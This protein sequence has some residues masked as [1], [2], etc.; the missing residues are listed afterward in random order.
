MH[1]VWLENGY[2][3]PLD[4]HFNNISLLRNALTHP[5]MEKKESLHHYERLEFL[6]N[7]IVNMIIGHLLYQKY[8]NA[9]EGKL[10]MM[11]SH[12]VD[13]N[14]LSTVA[15]EIN[16]AN[17]LIA[18]ASAHVTGEYSKST[19][20]DSMESLIAAI[21]LDSNFDTIYK[22]IAKLWK[23]KIDEVQDIQLKNYK[24]YRT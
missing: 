21:Y 24:S 12:L 20:E 13:K 8:S 22:I 6:G 3:P 4:Y 16:I 18:N 15:Q 7:G 9:N 23:D 10:S 2:I 14:A 19:L 5:S 1:K 11:L 17:N